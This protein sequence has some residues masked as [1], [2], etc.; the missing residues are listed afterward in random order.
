[1]RAM[2]CREFGEPSVLTMGEV[3]EPV[4][5]PRQVKVEVHSVGVNFPDLLLVAGKYQAKPSFPFSPGIECAGIVVEL[6]EGVDQLAVGDRIMCDTGYGCCSEYVLAY[7][8]RTYKLPDAM[9]FDVAGG[10]T[11]TYGTAY[12]ALIDRAQIQPGEV[13]LVHGAAGGVGLN[14]VEIGRLLGAMVIG[15]VGS[16]EKI[17]I[18]KQYGADHVINYNKENFRDVVKDLTDGRG[19]DVIYDPVGGD[20]FDQSMRCINWNGRLL[21]IGF[22]SGRIPEVKA[23]LVLLKGCQVMGVIWGA[24]ANIEIPKNRANFA[25]LF[26]WVEQGKINPHISAYYP[27]EATGEA[28]ELLQSREAKGKVIVRVRD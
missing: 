13:L 25:T 23:N 7:A 11:I 22:A 12:H 26:D 8:H 2:L 27:L 28:I 19:A 15:T 17:K 20:V 16:D 1:M 24:F 21:V 5:G 3:D 18:V 6:G 10:F 4:P 9:P 14:A